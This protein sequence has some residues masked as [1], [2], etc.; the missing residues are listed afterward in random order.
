[1]ISVFNPGCAKILF[2]YKDLIQLNSAKINKYINSPGLNSGPWHA[3]D[4]QARFSK[5]D[6]SCSLEKLKN[7]HLRVHY[8]RNFSSQGSSFLKHTEKRVQEGMELFFSCTLVEKYPAE[9]RLLA[10]RLNSRCIPL[11]L[12]GVQ[13]CDTALRSR[14]ASHLVPCWEGHFDQLF[15]WKEL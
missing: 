10:H 6:M 15:F 8:C 2:S 3:A 12:M 11:V 5:Q 4:W 14:E 13:Y 1:M 7:Q 9:S